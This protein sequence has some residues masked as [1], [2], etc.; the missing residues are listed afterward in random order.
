MTEDNWDIEFDALL[1]KQYGKNRSDKDR[2]EDSNRF[3]SD[4]I[5]KAEQQEVQEFQETD[6]NNLEDD[7]NSGFVNNLK[8]HRHL[9][10]QTIMLLTYLNLK[11]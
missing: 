10:W 7:S 3:E 6:S 11:I 1:E 8:Q 9:E 4:I 2:Y 5:E